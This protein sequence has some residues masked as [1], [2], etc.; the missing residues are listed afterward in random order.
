[1]STKNKPKLAP[2]QMKAL[3]EYFDIDSLKKPSKKASTVIMRLSDHDKETI[4]ATAQSLDLSV[5]EYLL[6]CHYMVSERLKIV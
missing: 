2:E 1:M 3:L 5:T 6:R 4:K